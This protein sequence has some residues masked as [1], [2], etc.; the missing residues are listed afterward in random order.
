VRLVERAF[1]VAYATL[2]RA[3]LDDDLAHPFGFDEHGPHE[4]RLSRDVWDQLRDYMRPY[5]YVPDE[6]RA[7][8]RLLGEPV[9]VDD[10]LPPNSMLLEPV[11]A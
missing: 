5:M 10:D 4:W 6:P 9:A 2:P 1:E 3:P 11:P 8:T 7:E